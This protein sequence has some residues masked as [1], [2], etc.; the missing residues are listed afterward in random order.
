M[1]SHAST[2]STSATSCPPPPSSEDTQPSGEPTTE[3][4]GQPAPEQILVCVGS[5]AI[6]G[7]TYRHWET[8]AESDEEPSPKHSKQ[9]TRQTLSQVM[10]FLISADWVIGEASA[11]HI[12][13]S[14]AAISR[15]FNAVRRQQFPK[16]S[17]FTAFLRHSQETVADLKLRVE[18]NL[19]SQRIQKHVAA[20][21]RGK[22]EQQRALAHFVSAF[23]SK[24]TAQTYCQGGL[25]LPGLRARAGSLVS[26]LPGSDLKGYRLS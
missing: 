25:R 8:V 24:W 1:R 26:R 11:L 18:L 12:H 14:P 21:H 16:R 7:A 15:K 19:L 20:G 2:A 23:R 3:P 5:Q 13:I 22:R 4:V 9:S 17:E 10:G 6:T